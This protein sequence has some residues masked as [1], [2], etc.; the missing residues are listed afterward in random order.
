EGFTR[1]DYGVDVGGYIMKDKLWFFGAYDRVDNSLDS[2]LPSGPRSGKIV[3]SKSRRNLGSAKL[4]YNLGPS[5]S[6]IG[7]FLQDPRVDTGA[8]NDNNHTLNGDQH[9]PRPAGFR[10]T[11]LRP[12]L[13]RIARF[14]LGLFRSG[15]ASQGEQFGRAGDCGG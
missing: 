15:G 1:K 8:I 11:R 14:Q 5:Q 9:L 13:R 4:T 12:A 3:T 2:G 10:R 7:T 6:L